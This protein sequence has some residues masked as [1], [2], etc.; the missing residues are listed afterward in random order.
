M[1]RATGSG[2]YLAYVFLLL[3]TTIWGS[4]Y[5][6][7]RVALETVP[8]ITLLCLR[9]LFAV[10]VLY[11]ITRLSGKSLFLQ[12]DDRL[13]IF[14]IGALGN[15]VAIGAQVFGTKYAG[16]S[17]ASLINSIN[18][19]FIILFAAVILGEKLSV[20]K[21]LATAATLTGVVIVLG[22]A[23]AIDRVWGIAF[24]VVSVILWSMSSIFIRQISGKYDP[25]VITMYAIVVAA[26]CSI[27]AAALELAAMPDVHL[28]S[29]KNLLCFV[30]LGVV[31][32]AL[33][34]LMWNK[35]LSLI[36][37][38]ACSLFYPVQPLVSASL[39]IV[40]LGEKPG[41]GFVIGGA[42][43]VAG[44]VY[45]VMGEGRKVIAE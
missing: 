22:R 33:P 3:T 31:C 1:M 14:L 16:A 35:S 37:A 9:Y 21:L 27:P 43:I 39:G 12:P 15:F 20:R 4:L 13:T 11:A 26:V 25:M 28:F 24:S 38:G 41:V 45:A 19:V 23:P 18:P 17:V 6:V 42:L 8:P 44:I 34:N 40:F 36:E 7:T 29:A 32:T 10:P 30:Y 2:R 5:V